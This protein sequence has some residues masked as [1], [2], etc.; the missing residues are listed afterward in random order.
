MIKTK[1]SILLSLQL[2]LNWC[3]VRESS[4]VSDVTDIKYALS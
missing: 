4:K 2:S 1:G 3:K